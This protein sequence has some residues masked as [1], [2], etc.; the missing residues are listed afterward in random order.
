MPYS[1][2]QVEL[3]KLPEDAKE[4]VLVVAKKYNALVAGVNEVKTEMDKLTGNTLEE[5]EEVHDLFQKIRTLIKWAHS[6]RF[7]SMV[8]IVQLTGVSFILKFLGLTPEQFQRLFDALI[9]L[10]EKLG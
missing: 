7:D 2:C 5:K 6:K 8:A 10:L 9:K 4:M 3:D 1:H